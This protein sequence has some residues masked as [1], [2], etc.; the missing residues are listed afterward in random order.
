MAMREIDEVLFM[1]EDSNVA[2]IKKSRPSVYSDP[3]PAP[4]SASHTY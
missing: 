1:K 2:Y 3:E 4:L